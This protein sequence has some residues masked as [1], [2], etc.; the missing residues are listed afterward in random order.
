MNDSYATEP[1]HY[2]NLSPV[3]TLRGE[4]RAFIKGA[5]SRQTELALAMTEKALANP[6]LVVDLDAPAGEDCIILHPTKV[7]PKRCPTV[8]MSVERSDEMITREMLRRASDLR[9]RI[10]ACGKYED[11]ATVAWLLQRVSGVSA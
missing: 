7:D 11:A 10:A 2:L 4:S 3:E 5:L 9:H 8:Q 6:D 1:T